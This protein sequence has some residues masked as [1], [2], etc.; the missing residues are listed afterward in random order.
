MIKRAYS[1]REAQEI[2]SLNIAQLIIVIFR[3]GF[4]CTLGEAWRPKETASLYASQGKGIK[5][6]QHCKKLALDINLY[7]NGKYLKKTAN[8]EVFGKIWEGLHP[9]CRWGGRWGDGNHYEFLLKP[10]KNK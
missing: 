5:D 8:H 9:H 6:S 10:R 2:F 7:Q 4:T 3:H 1:L